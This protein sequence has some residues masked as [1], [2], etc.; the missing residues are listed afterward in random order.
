MI[1]VTMD[2]SVLVILDSSATV[3]LSETTLP[4]I[5]LI[6]VTTEPSAWVIVLLVLLNKNVRA[7][8]PFVGDV[9]EASCTDNGVI[10]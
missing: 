6:V 3:V 7:E 8:I 10:A 4:I 9:W 5:S 2:P 1:L